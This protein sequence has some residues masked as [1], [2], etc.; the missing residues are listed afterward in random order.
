MIVMHGLFG[1]QRNNR[2]FSKYGTPCYY[3]DQNYLSFLITLL[4]S[5]ALA[6]TTLAES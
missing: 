6:D 5:L 3:C 2:T 1:S 4:S